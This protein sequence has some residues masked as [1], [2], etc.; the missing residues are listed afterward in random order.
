MQQIFEANVTRAGVTTGV[1]ADEQTN[2][3]TDAAAVKGNCRKEVEIK[4]ENTETWE[5]FNNKKQQQEQQQQEQQQQ[6]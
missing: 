4:A 3:Q 5:H 1:T 2:K 6:G